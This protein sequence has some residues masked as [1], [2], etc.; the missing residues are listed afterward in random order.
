MLIYQ[1][2]RAWFHESR[3]QNRVICQGSF[4][5]KR[6][7]FLARF[8]G[9]KGMEGKEEITVA[10]CENSCVHPAVRLAIR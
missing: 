9:D 5:A 7:S 8:G 6:E 4:P 1:N 10:N 3:A 2:G